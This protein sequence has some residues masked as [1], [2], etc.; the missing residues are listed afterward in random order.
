MNSTMMRPKI[1]SSVGAMI[2]ILFGSV[3]AAAQC[4]RCGPGITVSPRSLTFPPQLV[5]TRSAALSIML[6]SVGAIPAQITGIVSS[7]AAYSQT[8]TCPP[9]LREGQA[10]FIRVT[11]APKGVGPFSGRITIHGNVLKG[12]QVVT[13]SGVGVAP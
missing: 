4:T 11:F 7:G 5:H 10:C 6:R 12:Q 9:S 8:N 1:A 3:L 13:L 2:L